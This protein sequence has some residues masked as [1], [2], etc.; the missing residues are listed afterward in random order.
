MELRH[1]EWVH[2][3]LDPSL[4]KKLDVPALLISHTITSYYPAIET[5]L[6]SLNHMMGCLI[7][8]VLARVR[9]ISLG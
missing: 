1:T 7:L 3:S 6:V 4:A 9:Y 5:P 8:W 2:P